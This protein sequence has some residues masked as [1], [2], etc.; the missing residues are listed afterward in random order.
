MFRNYKVRYET[1]FLVIAPHQ[2][3]VCGIDLTPVD[4]NSERSRVGQSDVQ[5]LLKV[6]PLTFLLKV[7][8]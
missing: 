8:P 1:G 7:K 4:L 5:S 3:K 2:S 6:K